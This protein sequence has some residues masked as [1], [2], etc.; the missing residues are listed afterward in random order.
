MQDLGTLGGSE[1]FATAINDSGQVTGS[2]TRPTGP[3][4][5]LW[6]GTTMLDLGTLGGSVS[7]GAAMND[8]GQVTGSAPTADGAFPAFL[9]DGTTMIDLGT[10]GGTSAQWRCHQR[11]GAGDGAF[12]YRRRELHAF[13]WDGTTMLDLGTL[14][15][16]DS[17][18]AAINASGQVTGISFHA[19]VESSLA[20]LWDGNTMLDLNALI[21]PADPLQPFVTHEAALI[22]TIS[23]R[24]WS[25]GST[26]ELN[27][28]R[29][30]VVSP[31]VRVPEPGTLALLGLG[32]LGLGLTR[33]RA[34]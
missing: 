34:N 7:G 21:D 16:S 4:A 9:W 13:L 26:V 23:D 20:F 29:A 2:A 14:G 19:R 24:S 30:Y 6:D 27:D 12:P 17:A 15:G 1:S 28:F 22:S 3:H 33:R 31:V 10:L 5:F 8:S 32:L 25:M 11:L 18:G